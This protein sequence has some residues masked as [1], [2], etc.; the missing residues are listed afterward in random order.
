[1]NEAT[2]PGVN[3]HVVDVPAVNSEEDEVARRERLYGNRPRR[4]TLSIGRARNLHTR[5]PI[6]IDGKPAAVETLKI[7]APEVVR[8]TDKLRG[9]LRHSGASASSSLIRLA[10]HAA[11]RR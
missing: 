10:R 1:M 6:D 5:L 4:T 7:S 8:R 3:A 9:G 2:V 11:A